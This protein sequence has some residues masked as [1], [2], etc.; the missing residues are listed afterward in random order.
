MRW[1]ERKHKAGASHGNTGLERFNC[2]DC[3]WES[4]IKPDRSPKCSRIG[5]MSWDYCN[6]WLKPLQQPSQQMRPDWC[7]SYNLLA[8]LVFYMWWFPS[9]KS[10]KIAE[11]LH[12]T[13]LWIKSRHSCTAPARRSIL[14]LVLP[15]LP[16][17]VKL[18]AAC[19]SHGSLGSSWHGGPCCTPSTNGMECPT[20]LKTLIL[21]I[22]FRNKVI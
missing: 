5:M 21:T 3:L 8:E 4:E 14:H 7:R 22:F 10:L 2:Q 16:S 19:A 9:P 1:G 18:W 17:S 15:W 20:I 11:G 6:S 12:L 13:K